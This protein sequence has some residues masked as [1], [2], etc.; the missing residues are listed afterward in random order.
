MGIN[1]GANCEKE[2]L[3]VSFGDLNNPGGSRRGRGRILQRPRQEL[4]AKPRIFLPFRSV[5]LQIFKMY[6][7][8]SWRALKFPH[9][10]AS[11]LSRTQTPE[12]TVTH[13]NKEA[14]KT[15]LKMKKKEKKNGVWKYNLVRGRDRAPTHP[16][17]WK[18]LALG[19]NLPRFQCL[20][21]SHSFT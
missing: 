2:K 5:Y 21:L 7:E 15:S 11:L 6:I 9:T 20:F 18:K 8:P 19:T 13:S 12:I 1:D 16:L 14:S 17:S 4:N 10:K 3:D